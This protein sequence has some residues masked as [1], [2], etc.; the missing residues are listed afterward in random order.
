MK[1]NAKKNPVTRLHHDGYG[2][3]WAARKAAR[4]SRWMALRLPD[5][6]PPG[7]ESAQ[8]VQS[9]AEQCPLVNS[10]T[11][12]KAVVA[13]FENRWPV[14]SIG[15]ANVAVCRSAGRQL[16]ALKGGL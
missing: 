16:A 12:A 6:L 3:G 2:L 11:Q 8:L 5:V 14:L 9:V 10:A 7:E 4:I 1:T 15:S 13:G